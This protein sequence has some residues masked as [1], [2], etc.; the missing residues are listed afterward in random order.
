MKT[1]ITIGIIILAVVFGMGILIKKTE[2]DC[3]WDVYVHPWTLKKMWK[4]V[5][6]LDVRYNVCAAPG[7]YTGDGTVEVT[8]SE[9][10]YKDGG[11]IWADLTREPGEHESHG[12]TGEYKIRILH[13]PWV[14]T[15]ASTSPTEDTL[16]S[17]APRP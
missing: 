13:W 7:Y 8:A 15:S 4:T 9:N 14:E 10:W 3:F 5:A 2:G 17:G 1:R 11:T 16:L 12:T 6:A